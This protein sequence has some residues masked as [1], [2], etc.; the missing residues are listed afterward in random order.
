ML[1]LLLIVVFI[2]IVLGSVYY[3]N[4]KNH[5]DNSDLDLPGEEQWLGNSSIFRT[6]INMLPYKDALE[7]SKQFIYTIAKIVMQKFAPDQRTSVLALG[8]KLLQAGVK[9]VHVVDIFA[10]SLER[11]ILKFKKAPDSK[12]ISTTR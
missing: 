12:S 3:H 7:E 9:Y 5:K 11:K 2:I 6:N 10:L 4:T 1:F 8:K